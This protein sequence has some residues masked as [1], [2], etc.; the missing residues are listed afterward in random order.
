MIP[1]QKDQIRLEKEIESLEQKLEIALQA[2]C[3]IEDPKRSILDSVRHIA[4][5]A[6]NRIESL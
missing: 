5:E 3:K 1:E 4:M 2:L 6:V